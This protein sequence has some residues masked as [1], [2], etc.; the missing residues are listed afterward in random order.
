MAQVRPTEIYEYAEGINSILLERKELNWPIFQVFRNHLQR[1]IVHFLGIED[2]DQATDIGL[3]LRCAQCLALTAPIEF[4]GDFEGNVRILGDAEDVDSRWGRAVRVDYDGALLALGQI[5]ASVASSP[6]RVTIR[7]YLRTLGPKQ[8]Y[9]ILC[10]RESVP[11]FRDLLSDG[12]RLGLLMHNSS[13]F[14]DV[15]PMDILLKVGPLRS[16]G[17]GATPSS[18]LTAPRFRQ[19]IQFVWAGSQDEPDV[20]FDP[21]TDIQCDIGGEAFTICGFSWK[22]TVESLSFGEPVPEMTSP[23]TLPDHIA[24]LAVIKPQTKAAEDQMRWCRLL[25]LDEDYGMVVPLASSILSHDPSESEHSLRDRIAGTELCAGMYVIVPNTTIIPNYRYQGMNSSYNHVWK[26]A[27][28][29]ERRDLDRLVRTLRKEGVTLSGLEDA[30]VYWCKPPTTVV[31]APG[32][33]DH[34]ITLMKVLNLLLGPNNDR[35]DPNWAET[36]W[37][38]IASSRGAASQAGRLEQ[39][40]SREAIIAA[41]KNQMDDINVKALSEGHF[42]VRLPA[43]QTV[44]FYNVAAI[45]EGYRAPESAT[46]EINYL[47]SLYSWRV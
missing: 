6:L 35:P 24:E 7:D 19:L 40:Q 16:R 46:K 11:Y 30:V 9:G 32:R 47:R 31:H 1:L 15:V 26:E 4:D 36:A 21:L 5:R 39:E 22:R 27:L 17:W 45:E 44:V 33:K 13:D 3:Q 41:L 37:Q 10:H 23:S 14:R 34:F 29:H 2:D 12:K 42:E 18:I 43:K 8:T 38:E 28:I 25:T 20:A